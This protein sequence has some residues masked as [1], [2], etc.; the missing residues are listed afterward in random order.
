MCIVRAGIIKFTGAVRIIMPNLL[1][2][3][4]TVD[5]TWRFRNWPPSAILDFLKS[6][7]YLSYSSEDQ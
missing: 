5:E 4:R 3:G 1:A 2:I 6:K 7:F